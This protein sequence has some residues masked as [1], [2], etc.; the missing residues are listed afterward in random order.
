MRVNALDHVNISTV[1]IDSSAHFYA[2]LL[3]LDVRN[4]PAP[5]PPE[6]VRWLYD[7]NGHPIIHL[8]KRDCAPGSTGPL[9]HVAF[10]C[11]GK[12]AML[13][14]LHELGIEFSVHEI[15]A[16]KLTQIFTTDP[17]GVLLELNFSGE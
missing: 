6:Q 7:A 1:D 10:N 14:R 2:Q 13:A 12:D 8:V 3:G 9:H 16:L 15:S 17:H 5:L 11:S 4:G